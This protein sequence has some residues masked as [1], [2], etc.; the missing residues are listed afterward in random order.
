MD[1]RI[2]PLR[3]LGL[4]LGD[5]HVIRNAGGIVTDDE[6]RSLAISQRLLGTEEVV[7]IHHTECG[8][9][10]LDD[11]DFRGTLREE[12]GEEPEWRPGGFADLDE[13]V[14]DAIERVRSSPFLPHTG[15]VRGY[16]YDVQ[17]GEL[18]EV[19]SR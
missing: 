9:L 17:T 5:A 7:L 8:M 6:I 16:V 2:D 19:S 11:D 3:V 1:A 14:R 13:A 4:E 15:R 12:A 10:G 18:R